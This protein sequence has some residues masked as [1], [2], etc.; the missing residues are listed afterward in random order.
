M[1][2]D[3]PL[4]DLIGEAMQES[5]EHKLGMAIEGAFASLDE[6]MAIAADPKTRHLVEREIKLASMLET[7]ANLI[8]SFIRA[9]MDQPGKVKLVVNNGAR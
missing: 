9:T 8:A 3:D 7:R 6:V 5:P 2:Q 4:C 1:Y